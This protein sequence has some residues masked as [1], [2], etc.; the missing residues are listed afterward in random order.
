VADTLEK[1]NKNEYSQVQG[2]NMHELLSS[3][4]KEDLYDNG[5]LVESLIRQKNSRIDKMLRK[6]R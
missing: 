2:C 1:I 6:V 5:P 3:I 4:R